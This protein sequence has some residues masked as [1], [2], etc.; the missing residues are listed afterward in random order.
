MYNLD[1][2]GS[3]KLNGATVPVILCHYDSYFLGLGSNHGDVYHWFKKYGKDMNSVRED[4]AAILEADKKQNEVPEVTE[5]YK[6]EIAKDDTVTIVKGATY[7]NGKDVPNWVE[8]KTWIV[9]EVS[10]DRA[11]IDKSEDGKHSIYSPINVKYLEKINKAP[12]V[13]GSKEE[14]V[15]Y[16][17]KINVDVLNYRKGPGMEYQINGTVDK[18]QVY[19]I[20]AEDGD[21]GK[22]K[23]G[24]GWIYLPYTKKI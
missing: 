1:P 19:T 17:T 7:Y 14:L 24:A 10:G 18:G 23:S 5:E 6:A 16:L 20:V 15:P 13:A 3:V 2:K 9:K 4:V 21:W 8:A 22:L 11:V 12:T